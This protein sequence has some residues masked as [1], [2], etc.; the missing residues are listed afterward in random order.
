[1]LQSQEALAARWKS[2]LTRVSEYDSAFL[3]TEPGMRGL[4]ERTASLFSYV[5]LQ[6]RVP[7]K[8]PLRM[9]RRIIN[10]VLV[11]LDGE[12]RQDLRR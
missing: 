3:S 10:D 1:M 8:H 5:D 2:Q 6:D 12:V 4:D 11:A 9:I 7:P